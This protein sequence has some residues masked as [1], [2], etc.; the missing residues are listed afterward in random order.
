MKNVAGHEY[1]LIGMALD[2]GW[3]RD[4]VN[5]YA[6]IT[7]DLQETLFAREGPPDGIWFYE[8]MGFRGRPFMSPAMYRDIIQPGHKLTMDAAKSHG[9]P[10][11]VHSCGYVAPLIPGLMEAG[12]D[13]L[14]VIEVKAGMDLLGLYRD[15]GERLSFMGGIDVRVLYTNDRTLIDAELEAKIPIVKGGYGYALRSDHSIPNTVHYVTRAATLSIGASSSAHTRRLG[16]EEAL[17]K[18]PDAGEEGGCEDGV[19][20]DTQRDTTR[21]NATVLAV[22]WAP[23]QSGVGIRPS[24]R[25]RIWPGCRPPEPERSASRRLRYPSLARAQW[26]P[27]AVERYRYRSRAGS[28]GSCRCRTQRSQ[29]RPTSRACWSAVSP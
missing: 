10:V 18:G 7:V 1:M 6:Q 19:A 9:L 22:N 11:I 23:R 24:R 3:V 20:R 26:L 5:T 14:R 13:C 16:V 28:L 8:D 27:A 12:L 21:S 17:V 25:W 29:W 2:P 15:Y 4:M